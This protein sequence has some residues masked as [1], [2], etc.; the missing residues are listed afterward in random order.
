MSLTVD[1]II[2]R[3]RD[4]LYDSG[5]ITRW[6]NSDLLPLIGAAYRKLAELRPEASTD[7][8]A[9]TV[10][11]GPRQ[12]LDPVYDMRMLGVVRN[13]DAVGTPGKSVRVVERDVLD[14]FYA[15]WPQ[16]DA[17]TRPAAERYVAYAL[18]AQD[19]LAFW[20]FPAGVANDVILIKGVYLPVDPM[21]TTQEIDVPNAYAS[22]IVDYVTH[23]CL[24]S[25]AGGADTDESRR[26][27]NQ[28]LISIGQERMV[29]KSVGQEAARPP[30]AKA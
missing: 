25:E 20:L 4:Q 5:S 6:S 17:S 7:T 2:S 10:V 28:F 26:Y 29:Q 18:D 21:V 24:L 3:V 13:P 11:A 12:R 27:L 23:T 8:W 14:S 22:A 19:P 15:A 16:A 9:Y 30:E 1:N